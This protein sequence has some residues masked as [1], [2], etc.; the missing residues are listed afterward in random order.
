MRCTPVR[1]KKIKQMCHCRHMQWVESYNRYK[2][3][4]GRSRRHF[5]YKHSVFYIATA[6][7]ES[8]Q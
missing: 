5:F 6:I 7:D 4:R 2:K 1:E 3:C 8:D